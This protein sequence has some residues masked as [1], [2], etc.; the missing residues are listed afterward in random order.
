MSDRLPKALAA[1]STPRPTVH[2]LTPREL[3]VAS[4]LGEDLEPK[5]IAQTLGMSPNTVRIHIRNIYQKLGV[6]SRHALQDGR[7]PN[8]WQ[9]RRLIPKHDCLLASPY[10]GLTSVIKF[11]RGNPTRSLRP[12]ADAKSSK[13]LGSIVTR[14]PEIRPGLH[15][16]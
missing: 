6:R 4:H 5:H 13:S 11:L 8:L 14:M 3:Q 2:A 9:A 15:P 1:L 7:V 16:S 12:M 10:A